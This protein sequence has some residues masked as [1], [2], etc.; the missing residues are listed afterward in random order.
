MPPS[1]H[2]IHHVTCIAG[3]PQRNLNFYARSSPWPDMAP[4]Q[5][6]I[7]LTMEVI[8]AVPRGSLGYWRERLAANGATP[9]EPEPRFGEP[10]L[11]FGDPPDSRSRW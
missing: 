5:P 2:G 6:G 9:G 4:V 1:F 10:V 7:G 8:F 11:P 3:D